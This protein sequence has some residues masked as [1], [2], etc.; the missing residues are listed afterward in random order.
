VNAGRSIDEA[1][2]PGFAKS[3]QPPR[4]SVPRLQG[5]NIQGCSTTDVM[6]SSLRGEHRSRRSKEKNM[7]RTISMWLGLLAFA[8]VPVLAQAPPAAPTGKIH[9]HVV[10][11]TGAA[12]SGGT[13]SLSTD[14]GRSNKYTFAVDASGNYT[15]E[16]APG[17]Y[18]LVFRQKDTPPD[19]MV[20]S[21][22]GVK[23][24]SGQDVNVDDDM[25]R[26]AFVDK[27]PEEQKKQLEEIRKHNSEAL[28]ANEVIKNLNADLKQVTA[29]IKDADNARATAQQQLGASAQRTD[30]DAKE[31]EIK[32]A[33]YTEIES[34]MQKDTQV[35]PT[36]PVLFAYLGLGQAGQK[37]YD[38]AEASYKK[39]VELSAN[40]K[41]PK[42]DILGM[43]HAGLGEI[44][45]RA[46][47]VPEA[48]A[49][50]AEAAKVDPTKAAFYLRNEAVIFFQANNAQAQIAAAQEALKADPNQAVLYYII[51]QGL[52]QNATVDPK[53]NKI[54]LPPG[55]ADAYQKY[56]ELAPTGPY[57]ADAQGILAQ[58]GQKVSSTYKAEKKK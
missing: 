2:F 3:K 26:Q 4:V 32:T 44:Y 20:D 51:G 43:A 53:T 24:E 12:Q 37:K 48:N 29:D 30:V 39:V 5:Q 56:L 27:L 31:K 17:T 1:N 9:G 40:A 19:K 45:A 36:E 38:E 49:E 58:A 54:I 35:R 16:A 7:K 13:I 41:A 25:S 46:G 15:G 42:P 34:L 47:K 22:D 10:N 14:G 18:T 28:K 11:P 57:A 55:C 8:A 23:I 21:I 6:I 33:K 52:V 50:Y